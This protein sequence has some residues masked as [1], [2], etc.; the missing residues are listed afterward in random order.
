[1]ENEYLDMDLIRAWRRFGDRL[2]RG[3]GR[4]AQRRYEQYYK[5]GGK[6][7]E[8]YDAEAKEIE[9]YSR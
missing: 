1:M 5:G 2:L 9:K 8:D 6:M 7:L 4:N 3:P